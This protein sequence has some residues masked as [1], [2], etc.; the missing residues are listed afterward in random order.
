MRSLTRRKGNKVLYFRWPIPRAPHCVANN[1]PHLFPLLWRSLFG[2]ISLVFSLQLLFGVYF[3]SFFVPPSTS[4]ERWW[5]FLRVGTLLAVCHQ[6]GRLATSRQSR[7][8]AWSR[9]SWHLH[10]SKVCH[11]FCFKFLSWRISLHV[12]SQV[13]RSSS[14]LSPREIVKRRPWTLESFF[15]CG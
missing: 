2:Y 7:F 13:R 8:V 12:I 14:F 1:T 4:V 15:T 10:L 3:L 6:S 9:H 11:G 5:W